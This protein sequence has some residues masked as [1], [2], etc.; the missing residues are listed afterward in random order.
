MLLQSCYSILFSPLY[1]FFFN[2]C[3]WMSCVVLHFIKHRGS[4]WACSVTIPLRENSDCQ[5]D[6][7]DIVLKGRK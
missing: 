1:P 6:A 3:V 4:F 2:L 5:L 7:I